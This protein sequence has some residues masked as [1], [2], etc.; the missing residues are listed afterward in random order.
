MHAIAENGVAAHWK[1]K[2]GDVIDDK[3]YTLKLSW[4]R[5]LIEWHKDVTDAFEFLENIKLDLFAEEVF[6]FT[7]KGEVR[8]LPASS[9]AL[10]FAFSIHTEVGFRC[11]GAKINGRMQPLSTELKNGDVVEILTSRS[12]APK[13][14]WLNIVKSARAKSKIRSYFKKHER[15]E[16]T[17]KG[18]TLFINYLSKLIQETR[19]T[20]II[21]QDF[22]NFKFLVKSEEFLTAL[23]KLN[24]KNEEELFYFI[25]VGRVTP[26]SVTR[27]MFP[28]LKNLKVLELLEKKDEPLLPK[29]KKKK[30][31]SGILV[32]GDEDILVRLSKCCN[33]VPGDKI[34]GFITRGRGVSVH[35]VSCHNAKALMQKNPTRVIEVSWADESSVDNEFLVK[36]KIKAIDRRNLLLDITNAISKLKVNIHSAQAKSVSF[37]KNASLTFVLMV[38]SSEQL[39]SV[40]DSVKKVK[41][42]YS[43]SRVADI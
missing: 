42:V 15:E 1:Y 28:E 26:N 20:G 36:I 17:E 23:K 19:N 35:Q 29:R 7:P 41:G 38:K 34:I 4:L 14:D 37:D 32:K 22:L 10:D 30:S 25:G 3:E 27:N 9:T 18:R 6:V 12:S 8:V 5:Q 43:V 31:R 33:P 40:I 11:I 24:I 2:E 39:R 21:S 13:K 16:I